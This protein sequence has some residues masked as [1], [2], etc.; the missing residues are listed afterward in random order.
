MKNDYDKFRN[1]I[2]ILLKMASFRNLK[3]ENL[4]LECTQNLGQII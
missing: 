2:R 4:Y 1:K 3:V